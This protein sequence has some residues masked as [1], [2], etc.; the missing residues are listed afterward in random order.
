MVEM[1]M[2]I[3]EEDLNSPRI[4]FKHSKLSNYSLKM[5]KKLFSIHFII[6][7]FLK[8]YHLRSLTSTSGPLVNISLLFI[9]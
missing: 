8:G 6:Q 2:M 9:S 4:L 5:S 3:N 7:S 1:E